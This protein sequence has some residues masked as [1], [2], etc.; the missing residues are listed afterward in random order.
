MAEWMSRLAWAVVAAYGAGFAYR[1]IRPEAEGWLRRRRAMAAWTG[2]GP[3]RA[4]RLVCARRRALAM[5]VAWMAAWVLV[6]TA[7][8]ALLLCAGRPF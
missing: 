2:P 5:A 1:R 6:C 8:S 7:W 3:G 4:G